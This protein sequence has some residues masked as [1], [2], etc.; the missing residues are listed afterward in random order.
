MPNSTSCELS[1]LV[2]GEIVGGVMTHIFLLSHKYSTLKK[3]AT[4]KKIEQRA[5]VF[6]NYLICSINP[7]NSD[8]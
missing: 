6:I 2:N 8:Q 5:I 7:T 1:W 3:K 4:S